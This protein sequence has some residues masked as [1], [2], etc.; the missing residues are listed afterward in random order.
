MAKYLITASYTADGLKGLV[1]EKASARREAVRLACESVGGK[2]ECLYY[3]L[4]ED[5][6]VLIADLPDIVAAS[7]VS[8]A[9]SATGTVRTRTTALLTVEET[10]RALG[11]TVRFR[12]AG[13]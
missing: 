8:L 12:G 10:D 9:A 6:V 5:D 7:A 13:T 11:T 3:A 2:L 1:K 4:G